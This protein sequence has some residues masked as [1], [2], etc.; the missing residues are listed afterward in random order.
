VC[1]AEFAS[2]TPA[3]PGVPAST[4][5]DDDPPSLPC[6]AHGG[7]SPITVAAAIAMPANPL[8]NLHITSTFPVKR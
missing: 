7:T 3:P 8:P 5:V 2:A 6:G 4:L 1:A